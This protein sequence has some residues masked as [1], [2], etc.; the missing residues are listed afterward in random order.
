MDPT[1]KEAWIPFKELQKEKIRKIVDLIIAESAQSTL[2]KQE[3]QENELSMS[4]T[5][6]QDKSGIST[7]RPRLFAYMPWA[8]DGKSINNPHHTGEGKAW[9]VTRGK[10]LCLLNEPTEALAGN[11]KLQNIAALCHWYSRAVVQRR[12]CSNP[13]NFLVF[14]SLISSVNL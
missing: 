11:T 6:N 10:V 2:K 7:K 13:L 4:L 9:N 5:I 8:K 14:F 12:D 3:I 1:S